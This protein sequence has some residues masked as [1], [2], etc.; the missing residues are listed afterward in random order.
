MASERDVLAAIFDSTACLSTEIRTIGIG[1]DDP[2]ERPELAVL[3]ADGSRWVVTV[4]PR[5]DARS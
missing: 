4:A 2:D 5:E 1:P 3:M